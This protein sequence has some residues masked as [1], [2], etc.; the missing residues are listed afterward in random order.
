MRRDFLNYVTFGDK[1]TAF[2]GNLKNIHFLII[3]DNISDIIHSGVMILG[4]KVACGKT[5]KMM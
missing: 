2:T 5:F 1:D 4:Q 3:F